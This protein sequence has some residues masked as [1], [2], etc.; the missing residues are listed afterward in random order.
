MDARHH[1]ILLTLSS[2]LAHLVD[3]QND[4][5]NDHREDADAAEANQEPFLN[6]LSLTAATGIIFRRLCPLQPI[7]YEWH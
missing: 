6:V 2:C 3:N 5:A 1:L 4:N 7:G